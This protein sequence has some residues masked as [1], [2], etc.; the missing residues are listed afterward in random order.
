MKVDI[1]GYNRFSYTNR[2]GENRISVKVFCVESYPSGKISDGVRVFEVFT[3]PSYY[4]KISDGQ[5]AGREVHVSF[6]DRTHRPFLY[7]AKD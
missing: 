6:D 4:E 1:V 3:S 5:S 7:L 2:D